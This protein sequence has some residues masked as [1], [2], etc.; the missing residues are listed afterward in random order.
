MKIFKILKRWTCRHEW[1]TKYENH[2]ETVDSE[3]TIKECP[4][5]N[6]RVHKCRIGEYYFKTCKVTR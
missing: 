1:E 5:C 6:T 2:N 3:Y 4:K